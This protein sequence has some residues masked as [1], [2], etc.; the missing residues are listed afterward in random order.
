MPAKGKP[1]KNELQKLDLASRAA[2]LRLKGK[3]Y[4]DIGKALKVSHTE[5]ARIIKDVKKEWL[6]EAGEDLAAIRAESLAQLNLLLREAWE[7]YER[8]KKTFT[9]T[10]HKVVDTVIGVPPNASPPDAG[11]FGDEY[12]DEDDEYSQDFE[13]EFL[14][15]SGQSGKWLSLIHI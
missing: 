7:L 2:D 15:L 1:P 4:R 9:K 14:Q 6:K 13:R 12:P 8:S 11:G 10:Q 3:S 5:A